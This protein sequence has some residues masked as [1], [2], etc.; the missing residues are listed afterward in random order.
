VRG[1]SP[2]GGGQTN[3][4]ILRTEAGLRGDLVLI[5]RLGDTHALWDPAKKTTT[6]FP[7]SDIT[8]LEIARKGSSV[9][10]ATN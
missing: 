10:P 9:V 7:V 6:I 2:Q 8:S 5:G 4:F 1:T 3:T